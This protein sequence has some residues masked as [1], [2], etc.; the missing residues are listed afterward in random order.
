MSLEGEDN[1]NYSSAAAQQVTTNQ[2][3]DAGSGLPPIAIPPQSPPPPSGEN[4]PP[5]NNGKWRE[6]TKIGLEIFGVVL[7]FA[8]TWFTCLQWLQIRW[9]NNLTREALNYNDESLNRTLKKMQ[10]QIDEMHALAVNAG[11]QATQTTRL[12][13]D[14][15]DLAVS[16]KAQA[17]QTTKEAR[18]TNDLAQSAGRSADS[19]DRLA[20]IQTNSLLSTAH[21]GRAWL[22]MVE[23]HITQLEPNL[24]FK[25]DIFE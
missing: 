16:A 5:Q 19:A 9:T 10:G 22:G 21:S 4:Q 23:D 2:G 25:A 20:D 3:G 24:P 8:Y 7:L 13:T 6:N 15:H 14:T 12:A 17:E 11:T 1:K 18:A